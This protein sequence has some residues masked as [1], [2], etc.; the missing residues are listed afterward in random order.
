MP[1][2]IFKYQ[3]VDELVSLAKALSTAI[4]TGSTNELRNNHTGFSK[5]SGG[6]SAVELRNAL[7]DVRCEIYLRGQAGG[8]DADTARCQKFEPT[9]PL[10][11][12]AMRVETTYA[13]P[14]FLTSPYGA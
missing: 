14:Y 10:Q 12:K 11:E 6:L 3:S 7:R 13:P 4:T 5:T 9:N 2:R 1:E 8:D